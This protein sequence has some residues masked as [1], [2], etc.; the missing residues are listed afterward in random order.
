M[1]Y[2]RA[3]YFPYQQYGHGM[4]VF[5][6]SRWKAGHGQTGYGLGGLFCSLAK[7]AKP[8]AKSGA[9]ELGRIALNSGMN[10]LRDV[11][12]GKSVK[13]SA[14]ARALEG[15]HIAKARATQRALQFAQTGRGRRRKGKR[16][17]TRSK[18]TLQKAKKRKASTSTSRR[19]QTKK[20]KTSPVDIFG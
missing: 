16:L 5:R 19:Y 11:L 4:P 1:I 6:G 15:A 18:S 7:A 8:I 20:R 3:Q 10:I 2:P 17:S 14:K 13:E 9:K 12:A